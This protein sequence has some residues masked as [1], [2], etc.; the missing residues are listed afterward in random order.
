MGLE[1]ETGSVTAQL[2]SMNH[3]MGQIIDRAERVLF[4][5]SDIEDTADVLKGQ[6]YDT[7]RNYFGKIHTLVLRG[8]IILAE[9]II[10]EN[11][12]YKGCISGK[13]GGI[14][15]VNEDGLRDSKEEL[16]RQ[17]E[18]VYGLIDAKRGLYYTDWISSLQKV[19]ELIEKK[20]DQIEDF[21]ASTSGLYQNVSAYQENVRRGI[22]C[23]HSAVFD[24][25]AIEYSA[26]HINTG[27][28]NSIEREWENREKYRNLTI[29]E[30]FINIMVKEFGFD[31]VAGTALYKLYENMAMRGVENIN[32][33]Y[34]A[35]IAS[36]SYPYDEKDK[37]GFNYLWHYLAGTDT[38]DQVKTEML[39]YG[40]EEHEINSVFGCIGANH[41]NSSKEEEDLTDPLLKIYL[42]KIDMAHMA[43][44]MATILK[45]DETLFE[46]L[47]D[48]SGCFNGIYDLNANAG[49]VGDVYGTGGNGPKLTPDDYKADLDAVN[50]SARLEN[51]SNLI[52][53]MNRYYSEIGKGETNRAE[54]FVKNFGQGDYEAGLY[55]LTNQANHHNSFM[56]SHSY[57]NLQNRNIQARKKLVAN[58]ILNLEYKRNE[59]YKYIEYED[60][61]AEE[62][63]WNE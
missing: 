11:N 24:G 37:I 30:P 7:I 23:L 10:Q 34:L 41:D 14:G 61:V 19:I 16:E 40:L 36:V 55:Y 3:N 63:K 32:Q 28:M 38:P 2:D 46:Q 35:M 52:L 48:L 6:T 26:D 49:Y 31:R 9:A 51:E 39:L 13:L 50:L 54:E 21:K 27:W 5:V 43:V 29:K 42:R 12:T 4:C 17:L 57:F 22:E 1:M 47:G 58:F 20:L 15:Y 56:D 44:T 53:V 45:P 59:F 62:I 25:S 18:R 60:D 8:V 33:K